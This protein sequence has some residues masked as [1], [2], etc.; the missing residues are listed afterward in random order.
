LAGDR[1]HVELSQ[2]GCGSEQS[3]EQFSENWQG[4][5][6]GLTGHAEAAGRLANVTD[7]HALATFDFA[8]FFAAVDDARRDRD[9]GWYDLAD[10][11]WD[12]PAQLNAER[13]DHPLC[14]GAVSRLGARGETP[15][16]RRGGVRR[17]E[18]CGLCAGWPGRAATAPRSARG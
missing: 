10:E 13:D 16:R 5:I 9:M 17:A 3:A 8:A 2:V 6:E 11:L 15:R 18:S 1:T 4:I 7:V 14:G 12:Q